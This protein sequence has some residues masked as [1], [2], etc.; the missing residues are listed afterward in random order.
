[1]RLIHFTLTLT[2]ALAPAA[3]PLVAPA[4]NAP[5]AAKGAKV[6]S[7]H[8]IL[9][10][11]SNTHGGVDRKLAAYEADLRRNLPFDTFR[12]ATEG[13]VALP[14]KGRSTITF[15]GNHRLELED[16]PSEGLS[17]KVFWMNGSEVV[18]RTTLTLNPGVPAVLIRRGA[19]DGDVPVVL[20]MAR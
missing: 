20:L 14:N 19:S 15:A 8:A 3:L 2:L 6:S 10:N 9:I 11:A 5:K 7:V 4:A 13:T 18:I 17:L 12:Y 1:M 16:D